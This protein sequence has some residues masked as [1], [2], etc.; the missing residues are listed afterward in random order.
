MLTSG[1][2]ARI[3][4]RAKHH[5]TVKD[6][7]ETSPSKYHHSEEIWGC[8]DMKA[9]PLAYRK[10]LAVA[11]LTVIG[12]TPLFVSSITNATRDSKKD[13]HEETYSWDDLPVCPPKKN[14]SSQLSPSEEDDGG[15]IFFCGY[16]NVRLA[17]EVFPDYLAR[18][19]GGLDLTMHTDVLD[20]DPCTRRPPHRND[21]LLFGMHGR[22]FQNEQQFPGKILYING[23]P[24]GAD[25]TQEIQLL[26]RENVGDDVY[27]IGLVPTTNHHTLMVYHMAW[28]F[29]RFPEEVW[30]TLWD[31]AQ[32][33][34]NTGKYRALVYV[35]RHCV[36]HREEAVYPISTILPIHVGGQCRGGSRTHWNPAFQPMPNPLTTTVWTANREAF[37]EYKFCMAMENSRTERYISEKILVAFLAGCIPV[38]WGSDEVYEVFNRHAFI[39]YNPEDPGPAL[40]QIDTLVK[41]ETAYQQMLHHQP[42]LAQGNQTLRDYF[43]LSDKM[44]GGYLKHQLRTMMGL[45][46]EQPKF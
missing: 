10:L 21:I 11:L 25:L 24:K 38:Y 32:K 28:N 3:S 45:P 42:I 15:G 8:S 6:V 16:A 17:E 36:A 37:H 18:Y 1:A 27:Q 12:T 44:E 14:T 22:C 41:N 43:S 19:K 23:E 31:P 20:L 39:M 2:K 29:L 9:I 26:G 30:P 34:I 46:L 35:N 13:S 4:P 33:P 7:E 40:Q 5:S